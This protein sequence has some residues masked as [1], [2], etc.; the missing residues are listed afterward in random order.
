MEKQIK[1]LQDQVDSCHQQIEKLQRQLLNRNV[2]RG[3]NTV[4]WGGFNKYDHANSEIILNF[5]KKQLLPHYK[6]LHK[7]W[8]ECNPMDKGSLNS[9]IH[10]EIDLLDYM[11][12]NPSEREYFWMNKM[13]P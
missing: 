6:F 12:Q 8:K 7:S 1:T 10:P 11:R 9:K 4:S 13:V 5:C 2:H 3:R